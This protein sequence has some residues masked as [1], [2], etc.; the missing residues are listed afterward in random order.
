MIER[1]E[2]LRA[3]FQ[4]AGVSAIST[5]I[6][7]KLFLEKRSEKEFYKMLFDVCTAEGMNTL[8]ELNLKGGEFVKQTYNDLTDKEKRLIEAVIPEDIFKAFKAEKPD[9][10]IQ[11]P[12]AMYEI[13]SRLE[14]YDL[15]Y[16]LKY[17]GKVVPLIFKYIENRRLKN[18]IIAW[19]T[20][21]IGGVCA[22][23]SYLLTYIIN[24]LK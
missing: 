17:S 20:V 3:I 11:I 13:G 18:E 21:A 8:K 6:L 23:F 10:D 19:G 2:M 9:Y 5:S 1:L 12:A 16:I 24:N 15:Q 14:L 22:G 4:C 7:W